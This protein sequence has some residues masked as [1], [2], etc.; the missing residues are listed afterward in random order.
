MV[1]LRQCSQTRHERDQNS[2]RSH[3]SL[4]GPLHS[5]MVFVPA[6]AGFETS[7]RQSSLHNDRRALQGQRIR[8]LLPK[9]TANFAWANDFI[10]DFI[11]RQA[12]IGITK[13]GQLELQRAALFE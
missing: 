12:L 11:N 9:E 7:R 1:S 10:S 2:F 8:N 3:A 5:V 4:G 6:A 13:S